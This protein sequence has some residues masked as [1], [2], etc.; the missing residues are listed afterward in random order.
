[1]TTNRRD[2]A[3]YAAQRAKSLLD[4]SPPAV[5]AFTAGLRAAASGVG[6]EQA[7]GVGVDQ[8]ARPSRGADRG[9]RAWMERSGH[10]RQLARP[11]RRSRLRGLAQRRHAPV[12][13]PGDCR[14]HAVD[15]DLR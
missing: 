11:P 2:E 3:G 8:L 14:G 15:W 12:G 9:V 1:M 10:R 6:E 4:A 13:R 5:H 7:T